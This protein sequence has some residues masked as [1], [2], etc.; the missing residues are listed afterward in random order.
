LIESQL[1]NTNTLPLGVNK[2]VSDFV[3]ICNVTLPE[4]LFLVLAIGPSWLSDNSSSFLVTSAVLVMNFNVSIVRIHIGSGRCLDTKSIDVCWGVEFNIDPISGVFVVIVKFS[5]STLNKI[6]SFISKSLSS[7]FDSVVKADLTK[8]FTEESLTGNFWFVNTS[9]NSSPLIIGVLAFT[10]MTFDV[11]KFTT[12]EIAACK[13]FV[14]EDF[15][16]NNASW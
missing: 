8:T 4:A 11:L 12:E 2:H 7:N 14:L 13:S 9:G 16:A 15:L 10:E 3:H 6:L 5:V 1:G